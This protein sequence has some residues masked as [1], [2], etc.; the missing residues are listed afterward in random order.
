MSTAEVIAQVAPPPLRSTPIENPA[1][2]SIGLR[3]LVFAGVALA[4]GCVTARWL[5]KTRYE[6]FTGYLEAQTHNVS[7]S[8]DARVA[9]VLVRPGKVISA[10]QPLLTLEDADLLQKI[11]HQKQ[12]ADE[13]KLK[14]D[15]L[16]A[17]TQNELDLKRADLQDKIFQIQ[18]KISD[19]VRQRIGAG[20]EG[21]TSIPAD[22]SQSLLAYL[23]TPVDPNL[24]QIQPIGLQDLLPT[25]GASVGKVRSQASAS[26]R[27]EISKEIQICEKRLAELN[28]DSR[29]LPERTRRRTGLHVMQNKL[30]TAQADLA[31]LEKQKQ[32]LTINAPG[33]GIV[34]N[35]RKTAGEH[36][37][38][39]EAIVQVLDRDQPRLLLQIASYRV[40]DFPAGT[41]VEVKFPGDLFA[42]GKVSEVPPQTANDPGVSVAETRTAIEIVPAGLLWPELPCGTMVEVRRPR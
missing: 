4:L 39:N 25:D 29:D 31:E 34:G 12:V 5:S 30:T 18:L 15:Q 3:A 42:R 9:Q 13:L 14:V 20:I 28:N 40:A 36:V 32:A 1:G 11:N 16:E 24:K 35:Y 23:D 37:K 19:L 22:Q 26:V 8:R 38:A 27:D 21:Y 7:F 41:I 10:G 2:S 17:V 6:S 33:T